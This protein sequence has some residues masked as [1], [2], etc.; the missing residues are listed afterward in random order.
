MGIEF[1]DPSHFHI[2]LACCLLILSLADF[3]PSLS[4]VFL[5]LLPSSVF[6]QALMAVVTL[7]MLNGTFQQFNLASP[8]PSTGACAK[9]TMLAGPGGVS[10]FEHLCI[11]FALASQ[12]SNCWPTGQQPA[13]LARGSPISHRLPVQPSLAVTSSSGRYA[14]SNQQ[15]LPLNNSPRLIA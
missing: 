10:M 8:L 2:K 15:V 4:L 7:S 13:K 9:Q 14:T 6:F 5:A 11:E 3:M 12:P 1:G